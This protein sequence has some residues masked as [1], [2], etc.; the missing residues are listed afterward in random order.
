MEFAKRY[1]TQVQAQLGTLSQSAKWL[2]GSLLVLGLLVIS[3]L[4]NY[5]S[6]PEL[7]PIS[8]FAADR[9]GEVMLRLKAAGIDA[10]QQ[11]GQ[12]MVPLADREA[13]IALLVQDDLLG[14]GTLDAFNSLIE[15]GNFL[16][17][18]RQHDRAFLLAKNQVLGGIIRKM[19][20]VKSA[21]VVIDIPQDT[22]FGR[23][24]I[25][26]SASVTVTMKGSDAVDRHLVEAVARM[27]SGAV[28]QMNPQ[29]V[30][31]I[32]AAHGRSHTVQDEDDLLPTT[33]LE[34][35]RAQED[36]IRNK[37]D[38]LLGYI[39]GVI[40]A[41]NVRTDHT[42]R[43]TEE[44]VN[45]QK[46]EPLVHTID[47]E[48]VRKDIEQ[49]GN[50]GVRPNTGMTI[51]TVGG[52]GML[53]NIT[54]SE[55]MFGPQQVTSK[56]QRVVAGIQLQQVN[57]TINVPRAFFVR[58]W[59][60]ANADAENPP[61][62]EELAPIVERQLASIRQMVE[63]QVTAELPGQVNVAMVPDAGYLTPP[64]VEAG[65]GFGQLIGG[66]GGG[67]VSTATVATLVL[68][69]VGGSLYLI[70]RA[71][72]EEELPSL[73]QLAGIPP[74]LKSDEDPVGDADD[75]DATMS[76]VELSEDEVRT[77]KISGQIADLIKNNP[78]EAAGLVGKWIGM[79]EY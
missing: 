25:Q 67:W 1:W 16:A 8:Q 64:P 49:G 51:E 62:D 36:R 26:P 12:V 43:Q 53:E 3:L 39:P 55:S 77:R 54:K 50:P 58:V 68:L 71:T 4:V 66:P 6:S 11:G 74:R 48:I 24:H 69:A 79:E 17:S 73:E 7:A 40:V 15:N 31:V 44:E 13:A 70:R 65:G 19:K 42:L 37:L 56:I 28:A 45:Y 21:E 22:G 33:A 52:G 35:V 9:G 20:G 27:V 60:A 46:T 2:I 10:Q 5:V 75:L 30:V 61:T 38:T 63:P 34:M 32:D 47:E 18:N 57:V 41:V 23:N 29:D 78:A 72:R 14:E 59:Q 76:G